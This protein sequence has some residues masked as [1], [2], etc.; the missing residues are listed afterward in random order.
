MRAFLFV[1]FL[2]VSSAAS[3]ERVQLPNPSAK[4]VAPI[5]TSGTSGSNPEVRGFICVVEYV[6]REDG[7]IAKLRRCTNE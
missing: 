3:A 5:K 1:A 6:R 4:A 2:F 7:G